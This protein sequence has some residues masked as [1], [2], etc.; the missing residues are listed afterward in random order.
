[1]GARRGL[2]KE[3]GGYNSSFGIHALLFIPSSRLVLN[4]PGFATPSKL[5]CQHLWRCAAAMHSI[6][7]SVRS[8]RETQFPTFMSRIYRKLI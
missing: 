2:E 4:Q 6:I 3:H 8:G 1:M 5:R 7:G